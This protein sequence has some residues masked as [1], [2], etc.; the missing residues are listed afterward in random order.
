M[1]VQVQYGDIEIF[2]KV[3]H[4]YNRD[5]WQSIYTFLKKKHLINFPTYPHLMPHFLLFGKTQLISP[6]TPH[7]QPQCHTSFFL[8]QR[9]NQFLFIS[10]PKNKKQKKKNENKQISFYLSLVNLQCHPQ[11]AWLP[12]PQATTT[13]GVG[14]E[15]SSPTTVSMLSNL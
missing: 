14:H 10:R 4:E 8:L 13:E 9:T 1:Q 15:H 11:L 2:Q 6:P 7:L 5:T 3:R 12:Y